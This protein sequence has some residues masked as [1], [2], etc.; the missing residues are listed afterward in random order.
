MVFHSSFGP[1]TAR[2][3]LTSDWDSHPEKSTFFS[4]F[5][6]GSVPRGRA[7][8]PLR[9]V[10]EVEE[11]EEAEEG[12]EAEAPAGCQAR[13]H[14]LGGGNAEAGSDWWNLPGCPFAAHR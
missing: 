6:G 13:G 1:V 12:V 4:T 10:E 7:S 3:A 11:A 2:V 5:T 8:T 14:N 9:Q